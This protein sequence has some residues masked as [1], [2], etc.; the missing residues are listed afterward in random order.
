MQAES[1]AVFLRGK[2]VREDSLQVFMRY[3][4]AVVDDLDQN[5]RLIRALVD[6]NADGQPAQVGGAS[7]S[8][9]LA[10]LIRFT[11][12]WSSFCFSIRTFGILA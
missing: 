8:A 6:S 4:D 2:S 11:R 12:I 3:S 7:K 9:S 10:L 5:L 1:V